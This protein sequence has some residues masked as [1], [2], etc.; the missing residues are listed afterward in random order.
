MDTSQQNRID[1]STRTPSSGSSRGRLHNAAIRSR[2]DYNLAAANC[3]KELRH[4]VRS[5]YSR[6]Y[7]R[8]LITV[9]ITL[10]NISAEG[11]DVTV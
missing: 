11:S 6:R 1:L 7:V 10:G 9:Y 2:A 4:D 3:P 5:T 8:H